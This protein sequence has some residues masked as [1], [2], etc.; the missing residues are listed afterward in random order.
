M[1]LQGGDTLGV[2]KDRNLLLA[3]SV[4]CLSLERVREVRQLAA[5]F[6][7]SVLLKQFT[8]WKIFKTS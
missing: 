1:I 4:V 7:R 5:Q 2:A 8:A 6:N 3:D